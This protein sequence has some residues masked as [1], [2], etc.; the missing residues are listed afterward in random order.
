MKKLLK[1][2][3]AALLLIVILVGAG[4][5]LLVSRIDGIARG[6]IEKGAT[7]AMG[8]PVRL[9]S[10]NVGLLG[11]T[12]KMAGLEVANPDGYDNKHFLKLGSGGLA[13]DYRSLQTDVIEVPTLT[14]EKIEID[15]AKKGDK[16]NYG[17]IIDNLKKFENKDEPKPSDPDAGESKKFVIRRLEIKDVR[18]AVAYAPLAGAEITADT[19]I[20]AIVLNDVGSGGKPVSMSELSNLVIKAI[21]ESITNLDAN[22]MPEELLADLR[23]RLGNLESLEDLGV[24]LSADLGSGLVDLQDQAGQ[25]LDDAVKGLDKAKDDVQDGVREVKDTIKGIL[26]GG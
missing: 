26:G 4:V 10:V 21:L 17:Q 22:I 11:G 13:L 12:F 18:A 5:F 16:S 20:P 19:K 23:S 9:A 8:V 2:V 6:Q 24:T 14:L 1:I 7:I 3:A 15:I 25:V